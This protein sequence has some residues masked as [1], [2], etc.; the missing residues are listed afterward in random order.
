MAL[1]VC[2]DAKVISFLMNQLFDVATMCQNLS[3]K[4]MWLV[5]LTL[6]EKATQKFLFFSPISFGNS[7]SIF[8]QITEYPGSFFSF[9]SIPFLSKSTLF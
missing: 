6:E 5:S 1:Q 9:M 2:S 7:L 8:S 4:Y 3:V